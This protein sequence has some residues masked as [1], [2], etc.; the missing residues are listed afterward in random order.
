[1]RNKTQVK[2]SIAEAYISIERVIFYLMYLSGI[3]TRFNHPNRHDDRPSTVRTHSLSV[4]SRDIRVKAKGG[5]PI[6]LLDSEHARVHRYVLNNCVEC[7]LYLWQHR[8]IIHSLCNNVQKSI[9]R[10]DH[11]IVSWFL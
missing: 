9:I 5:L 2:V 7:E 1:V 3:D 10:H 11:E 6:I 4:F 8:Q